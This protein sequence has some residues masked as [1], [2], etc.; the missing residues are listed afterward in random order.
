[1]SVRKRIWKTRKGEIKEAWIVDYIDQ[2]GKRHIETRARKKQADARAAQVR[3][4]IGKGTHVVPHETITV[5]QARTPPGAGAGHSNARRDQAPARRRQ[6]HAAAGAVADHG[7]DRLRASELRG[8]R[9]SDVDLGKA[10]ELQVRQRAD[11]WK[12]IGAPK[13]DAGTR[14]VP[15]AP[16][17]IAAL[18]EWKLKCP[19]VGEAG[20]LVFGGAG[21]GVLHHSNMRRALDRLMR[22][23]HVVDQDGKAKYGLHSFR[24]EC[25]V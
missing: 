4:A 8:L 5:A 2:D 19:K 24:C 20:A 11:R 6:R 25:R 15:L 14:T 23:A 1:M 21:G 12:E 7:A 3:I 17:L 9:W 18:K 10:A 22:D 16:E 13:T